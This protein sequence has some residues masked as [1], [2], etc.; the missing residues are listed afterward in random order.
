M[1]KI[2]QRCHPSFTLYS[3]FICVHVVPFNNLFSNICSNN[4]TSQS[5]FLLLFFIYFFIILFCSFNYALLNLS[6]FTGFIDSQKSSPLWF[7][8]H[9]S[10]KHEP[11]TMLPL[12]PVAEL[13]QGNPCP[14]F[15][16]LRWYELLSWAVPSLDFKGSLGWLWQILWCLK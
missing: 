2:K 11:V 14:Y 12:Q 1:S 15:R 10:L 7:R 3:L 9:K 4:S 8:W 16:C 13:P 5:D 6:V